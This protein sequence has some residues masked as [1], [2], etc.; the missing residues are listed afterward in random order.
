MP[1]REDMSL[2]EL[3][4]YHF[5]GSRVANGGSTTS[6]PGNE[7]SVFTETRGGEGYTVQVKAVAWEQLEQE[8]TIVVETKVGIDT[9]ISSNATDRFA[10]SHRTYQLICSLLR[11]EIAVS[12]EVNGRATSSPLDRGYVSVPL[13]QGASIQA[14][15]WGRDSAAKVKLFEISGRSYALNLEIPVTIR[16]VTVSETRTGTFASPDRNREVLW[17]PFFTNNEEF[18]KKPPYLT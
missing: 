7:I 12:N 9:S 2:Q 6:N 11:G 17:Y 1:N 13:G 16:R 15:A 8:P 10:L 18:P 5:D 4:H 3:L 14:I